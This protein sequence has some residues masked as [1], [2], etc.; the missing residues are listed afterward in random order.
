[1]SIH[2]ERTVLQAAI[3][4]NIAVADPEEVYGA[5]RIGYSGSYQGADVVVGQPRLL[6][7]Q[8]I[9]VTEEASVLANTL[10][11][12]GRTVI[13]VASNKQVMGMLVL[14]DTVRPEASQVIARL[15]ELGN[16]YCSD[17]RR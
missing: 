2:W 4:C 13:L 16:S 8:G 9:S 17:Y 1:V 12:I 11:A 10:A 15:K 7:K 3:A 14:E 6:C 5:A